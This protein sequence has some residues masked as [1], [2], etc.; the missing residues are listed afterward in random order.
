MTSTEAA[1]ESSWCKGPTLREAREDLADEVELDID[2]D[3]TDWP[4][5]ELEEVGHA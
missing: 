2:L 4:N 3:L 1:T 5:G